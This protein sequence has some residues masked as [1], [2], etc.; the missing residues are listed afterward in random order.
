VT[1]EAT[2]SKSV[3]GL[4]RQH[5]L[6]VQKIED[7]YSVGIP[8]LNVCVD[9]DDHWIELKVFS[10]PKRETTTVNY[11]LRPHQIKWMNKRMNKGSSCWLMAKEKTTGSTLLWRWMPSLI[12]CN[13]AVSKSKALC[14]GKITDAIDALKGDKYGRL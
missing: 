7:K 10:W 8:D 2:Y 11:G 5:G 4:M 1:R 9:G 6:L 3:V 12:T 13:T 14:N